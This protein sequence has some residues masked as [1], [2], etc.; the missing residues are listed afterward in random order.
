MWG[1]DLRCGGL[2][3]LGRR[4]ANA[5]GLAKVQAQ[6]T[7]PESNGLCSVSALCQA[8]PRMLAVR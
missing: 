6:K 7:R 8:I 1:W 5:L 3:C 2:C 4:G